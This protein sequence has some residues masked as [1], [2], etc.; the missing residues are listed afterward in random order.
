M[1][2]RQV[3]VLNVGGSS[4][5]PGAMYIPKYIAIE[6]QSNGGADFTLVEPDKNGKPSC[7]EHGAMNK[8]T[9]SPPGFWRCIHSW[10]CR[11]ACRENLVEK[12]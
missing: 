3:L 1:A 6:D 7:R 9:P 5:P 8:V 12:T 4:P 10:S 11:A 2:E